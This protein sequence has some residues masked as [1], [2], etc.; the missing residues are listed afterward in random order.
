[1]EDP[2]T[3]LGIS[4]GATEDEIKKAY[5]K[6]AMKNHPDKGG[7]P[8]QFKKIQGAYERITKPQDQGIPQ[9][10]NPFDMFREM[11]SQVQR[12][13]HEVHTSVKSAYEGQE[14]RFKVS[15]SKPC[16]S[17]KCSTCNGNGFI[18]IALFRQQCPQCTGRK[19][20]GCPSCNHKGSYETSE[21]YVVKV[22]PG[23]SSG[24][25]IHVCES[26]DVRI[27]IDDSDIFK[28]N[29][30]DLIYK[31]NMTFKESLIGTTIM[32][33]HPGGVFEYTTK[34][35]KPHKK[36]IVK[37]KGISNQGNLILDFHI[38]YPQSFT[39]EQIEILS[40]IL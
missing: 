9:Q 27:I 6:L 31:V 2:Y 38:D 15:D 19:A 22:P 7:D 28:V 4:R 1:M 29:G 10:F 5:R 30:C 39:S 33:P 20:T 21:T 40:K 8:E 34:F 36:Y 17:C 14:L 18:P 32:V 26:F 11:F 24:S 37:G 13:I 3:I 12:N 23:V 25:I 16:T 35:I